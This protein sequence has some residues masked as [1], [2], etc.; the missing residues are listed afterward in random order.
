MPPLRH[1]FVGNVF[2][3]AGIRPAM[4]LTEPLR[5]IADGLTRTGTGAEYFHALLRELTESLGLEY[6]FV[7]ELISEE[8]LRGRIVAARADGAAIPN[9]EFRMGDTPCRELFEA[10]YCCYPEGV[11]P[12][13]PEDTLFARWGAESFAGARLVDGCGA[14]VGWIAL[15]G[16]S[17]IVDTATVRNALTLIARRTSAEL[18]RERDFAARTAQLVFDVT[19]DPL[20]ELP[21]RATFY[22]RVEHAIALNRGERVYDFAVLF[23]DL[24][25]FQLVNDSHGY[26]AG[27]A[28]ICEVARRVRRCV[29]ATDMVARIGGDE[30]TILAEAIAGPHDATQLAARILDALR[31]PFCVPSS[32]ILSEAKDPPP[33]DTVIFTSGSIGIAVGTPAHASA[34]E[35][36][37]DAGTAMVRAKARGKGRYEVF[38]RAMHAE[39]VERMQLETDLRRA[40]ERGELRVVYQPV[41]SLRDGELAGFEALLRWEHPARGTVMPAE[42]IS[43]AEETGLIVPIGAAA[44]REVCA[45]MEELD[46]ALTVSVNLSLHQLSDPNLAACVAKILAA[47]PRRRGRLRFEITESALMHD[48]AA[49]LETFAKIRALGIELCIDDFGTGYSSLSHLMNMPIAA[50]K[51]DRSFIAG[52]DRSAEMVRTIIALAHNLGLDTVA[53]GVETAEQA[54]RLAALDCD[55]AQGYHFARPLPAAEARHYHPTETLAR[56]SR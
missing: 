7:A 38:D 42:F 22:D 49:A 34:E 18:K 35:I 25:R 46:P 56:A 33:D 6:G 53:E 32:V 5:K 11:Q 52:I 51:I 43:I 50:L 4:H 14:F 31:E 17:P 27:D 28:L 26:A 48:A 30:L 9:W 55:Y 24:D 44:L 15:L 21:N 3:R 45:W 1:R 8:P 54:R 40:V 47:H 19:H 13:F 41:V 23:L 10:E 39:A 16:R 29:R 36:V 37:R 12:C 2:I 20:T